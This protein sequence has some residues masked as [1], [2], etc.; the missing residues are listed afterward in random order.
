[1]RVFGSSLAE[2]PLVATKQAA[3]RQGH[4]RVLVR[5]VQD[6]LAALGVRCL[7]LPAARDAVDT[8]IKG[9]GF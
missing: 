8:W 4:C 6:K 1:M 7:A 2:L 3:R 9:F 5:E